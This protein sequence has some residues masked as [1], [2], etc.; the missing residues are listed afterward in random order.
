M[1]K[2]LICFVFILSI[3]KAFGQTDDLK[4]TKATLYPINIPY[5]LVGNLHSTIG[6]NVGTAGEF[7]L[8]AH[9]NNS[10][11]NQPGKGWGFDL[12]IRTPF[13]RDPNVHFNYKE[14][15]S[16]FTNFDHL[17]G[18]QEYNVSVFTVGMVIGFKKDL[19]KTF[20]LDVYAGPGVGSET[21][22]Y[23]NSNYLDKYS[24][25]WMIVKIGFQFGIKL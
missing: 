14:Y 6:F 7:L 24:N 8:G 1:H 9:V 10:L 13:N 25:Q 5:L 4:N 12:E 2:S 22:Q 18:S 3:F 19:N 15:W 16:F 20:V 21:V 11:Q 23:I 17:N